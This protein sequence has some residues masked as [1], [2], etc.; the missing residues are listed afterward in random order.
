MKIKE[1]NMKNVNK[2]I[3]I[4]LII[5]SFLLYAIMPF[6]ICLPFSACTI[7][8]ITGGMIIVSEIIFWIGCLMIGREVALKIKKKFSIMRIVNCMRGRKK[9]K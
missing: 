3:A 6:N 4:T 1:V 8:G 5:I 2:I 9:G 7:A